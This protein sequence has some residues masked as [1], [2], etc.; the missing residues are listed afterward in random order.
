MGAMMWNYK[1]FHISSSF[2]TSLE[3]ADKSLEE[4]VEKKTHLSTFSPRTWSR[5]KWHPAKLSIAEDQ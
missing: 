4:N 1:S 3:E 5:R 2:S